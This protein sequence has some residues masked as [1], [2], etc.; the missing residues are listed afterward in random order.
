VETTYKKEKAQKR[1]VLVFKQWTR[2]EK[3]SRIVNNMIRIYIVALLVTSVFFTFPFGTQAETVLRSGSDVSVEAD[4]IVDGDYYVSVGPFGK[5]VMSGSVTEDMIAFGASVTINGDIGQDV[6]ILSGSAHLHASVTDDVRIFAGEVTLADEVGGDVFVFAGS[7]SVLSTATIKG[8]IFFFGGDLNIEG[9]VEGSVHGNAQTVS[10]NSHVAGNVDI[11]A[12]VGLSL[13]DKAV[14]DGSI[15]YKSFSQLTRGQGAIVG[16]EVTKGEYAA[17]TQKEQT[18]D[19]LIPIFITLFATLSLYL[20]FKKELESLIETIDSGFT[21]NILTGSA[22]V[23]LG[24]IAAIF[25]MVTVLGLLVGLMTLSVVIML[26]V[27]GVA[28]SSVVLGAYVSRIFTKKL[29][30][31]LLTIVVGTVAVQVLLLIPVIGLLGMYTVFALTVGGVT[32]QI[33]RHFA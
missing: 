17:V 15:H 7:L 1:S 3:K 10:I 14:I 6:F 30:V 4:Q 29:Q 16:G 13:G 11:T 25:L 18:R 28:L 24:P 27:A 23:L 8:D 32:Q 20:L 31:T 26:Y 33:Y 12:Q 19:M 2:R 21:R 9:D 22:V 5:T